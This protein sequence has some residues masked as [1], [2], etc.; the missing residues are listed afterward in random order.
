MKTM[1][2]KM[3]AVLVVTLPLMLTAQDHPMDKLF[4]KYAGKDCFTSVSI[5]QDMFRMLAE[6]EIESSENGDEDF[7]EVQKMMA[8][9]SGLKILTFTPGAGCEG[10]NFN[11][12]V[13]AAYP[14]SK[15]TELMVVQEKGEEARFY[16][17]KENNKI[18]ELLMIAREEDQTI[19]LSLTGDIDLKSIS[20]LGKSMNIEGMEN[21]EKVE[22]ENK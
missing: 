7:A 8:K 6:I 3:V 14:M 5:S 4:A 2:F 16:I 9:L 12:E 17:L 20:N 10:I 19:V 11:Q 18:P 15:Y 13:I 1:L 22:E 21:L